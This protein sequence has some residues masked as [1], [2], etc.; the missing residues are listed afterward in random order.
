MSTI[1][2]KSR[3]RQIENIKD[4]GMPIT[5]WLMRLADTIELDGTT[6]K[7]IATDA[8]KIGILAVGTMFLGTPELVIAAG[9][10]YLSPKKKRENIPTE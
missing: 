9:R 6:P 7:D 2:N 8:G 4:L 3:Q 1:E 10:Y 5:S